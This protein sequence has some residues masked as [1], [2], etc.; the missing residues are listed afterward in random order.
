VLEQRVLQ[1]EELIA[2]NFV[3]NSVTCKRCGLEIRK[4]EILKRVLIKPKLPWLELMS[5]L[6]CVRP[7]AYLN[8]EDSSWA[9]SDDYRKLSSVGNV[10]TL[11]IGHAYIEMFLPKETIFTRSYTCTGLEHHVIPGE[12]SRETEDQWCDIVCKACNSWLGSG[13]MAAENFVGRLWKSSINVGLL[14][15]DIR[16]EHIFTD[17]L[18]EYVFVKECYRF[19][20]Y[21]VKDDHS[22]PFL[23]IVV[24]SYDTWI[25]TEQMKSIPVMKLLFWDMPEDLN[26]NSLKQ[27]GDSASAESLT[28]F[29]ENECQE[30]VKV[31]RQSNQSFPAS[32]RHLPDGS[33]LGYL[34]RRA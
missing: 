27:W 17:I 18:M 6:T 16:W 30:I 23:R 12:V 21:N 7:E 3:T 14:Y 32:L 26:A 19:L 25:A 34:V 10:D 4:P 2:A 24:L 15:Q 13:K 22:A 9:F 11:T 8:S 33:K 28:F 5:A 20:L 29:S 31:L 1:D